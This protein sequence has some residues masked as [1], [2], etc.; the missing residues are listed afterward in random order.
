MSTEVWLRNPWNYIREVVEVGH[1]WLAWDRGLLRKRGDLDMNAFCD[2]NVPSIYDYRSMAIGEQG[3]VEV[4]RDTSMHSPKAVYPVWDYTVHALNDLLKLIE[5]PAGEDPKWYKNPILPPDQRPVKGQEHRIVVI[6]PPE[7]GAN[8][9]GKTFYPLLR[10][11]QDEHPEVILHLH[12]SY[13]YR[14][15]FGMELRSA[16][17]DPTT[18]RGALVYLPMGKK[19]KRGDLKKYQQWINVVGGRPGD[20]D[21]P[22]GVCMFNIRSALWAGRHFNEE[23]AFRVRE[24]GERKS[25]T[26]EHYSPGAVVTQEDKFMCDRCS[27]AVSCKYFR[28]GAVCSLPGSDSVELSRFFT[29]RDSAVIISGLTRLLEFQAERL[30]DGRETEKL[31]GDLDPEVTRIADSLFERALKLA[32]LL[33]PQLDPKRPLVSMSVNSAGPTQINNGQFNM[34]EAVAAAFT[35]LEA[36]GV[37]RNAITSDMVESFMAGK[38]LALGTGS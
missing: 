37:P 25:A 9:E 17:V 15:M 5:R 28:E 3:A 2:A 29:S 20:L 34:Q 23:V 4:D 8:V 31:T 12:G 10:D 32:K 11:I 24:V 26:L 7:F 18:G 14:A 38:P 21:T 35:A 19:V 22:R 1:C 33:D 6:R 13:S 27:L 16:D 36:K 30:E